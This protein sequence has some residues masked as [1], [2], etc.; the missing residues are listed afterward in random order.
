MPEALAA[1]E[2]ALAIRVR[3]VGP[4][5]LYV[6]HTRANHANIL[7]DLGR[8]DEA[9]EQ[10]ERAHAIILAARGPEHAEMIILHVVLAQTHQAR[11]DNERAA[12]ELLTALELLGRPEQANPSFQF[13]VMTVL[14]RVEADLG[15]GD[16]ALERL[17]VAAAL[18]DVNPNA[19]E[20]SEFGLSMAA[21][22][23]ATGDPDAARE[24]ID[25]AIDLLEKDGPGHERQLADLRRWR[26]EHLK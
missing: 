6:G 11:G 2:R 1:S 23:L 3:E 15:H 5:N 9:L 13:Q 10:A 24:Q 20:Q 22:R 12:A 7:R 8:L 17:T 25:A 18:P 21:A 14:A 4:D 16:R 26:T 19:E